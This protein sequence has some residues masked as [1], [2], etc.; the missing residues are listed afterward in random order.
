GGRRGRVDPRRRPGE[1]PLRTRHPRRARHHGDVEPRQPR[2]GGRCRRPGGRLRAD[3]RRADAA[4]PVPRARR[5]HAPGG[6]ARR[7]V[8]RPGRLRR[9][10]PTDDPRHPTY[11]EEEV[12]HYCVT[13][14][15]AAVPHTATFALT[16][17][18]L[19]YALEIADH[20]FAEALRRNSALRRASNVLAGRVT[21]PGVAEAAGVAVTPPEQL[22]AAL[23][24]RRAARARGAA[25]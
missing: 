22:L 5:R 17:A 2:G 14:M 20:G 19:S 9:D 13:N 23:S 8:H 15:P 10:V 18:T 7:P 25:P 24:G 12:V 11:V 16:N 1:A 3:P 6:R 21:H 4:P